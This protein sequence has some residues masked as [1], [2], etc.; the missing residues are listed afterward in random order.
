MPGRTHGQ[1]AVPITF[2]LKAASWGDELV[3][4]RSALLGAGAALPASLAGAAGTLASLGAAAQ[5]VLEAYCDRLDLPV[6]EGPWHAARF[7]L[8]DLCHALGEIGVTGERIAAEIVRLQATEIDELR[9]PAMPGHVG[10][11]TMPQKRN[12][13]TSE[14]LIGSARLLRG[15]VSVVLEGGAHAGE[16]DMGPWSAEWIAVPQAC[17]LASS[18]ADKLAWIVEGLEVRADRMRANLELTR[19]A[20]VA[21]EL[22]MRLGRELGHEA[23]HQLVARAAQEAARSGRRLDEIAI[24]DDPAAPVELVDAADYVGWSAR[25]RRAGGAAHPRASRGNRLTLPERLDTPDSIAFHCRRRRGACL[26]GIVCSREGSMSVVTGEGG[27]I[28]QGSAL[29]RNALGLSGLVIMGI[30]YMGLALT[31]Y[32]NFGIMEGITGPIVPLAFA[33]VT[34][35]MLPTAMSYAIM[36]AR[37]PSTGGTLTWLWEATTPPLGVWLGWVLVIAYIDGCILQPVMFG[38]FFNSL[39][40]YFGISTSYWTA[41][42]TGLISIVVVGVMT[43]KDIRVSAKVTAIFI[44]IEAGFVAL[45]ATYIIIKQAIDGNLSAQPLNPSA[46]TNGW[47]GFQNALLFAVLAI[48]AFDI[49]APMAEETKTPRK[50]VPKATIYVTIGAGLYWV[51]TSFGLINAVPASTMAAYV[52]SGEFTPIYL[53]ADHY[54]GYSP[55]TRAADRHDGRLRGVHGDLDR[56]EPHALRALTRGTRAA[57]V[58]DDRREQDARGTRRSSCS[59]A[60]SSCPC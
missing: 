35:A 5:P 25:G 58:R 44:A 30:A 52:N 47:T 51:I 37:R 46:A 17:I 13:M 50:L 39:L 12:P 26:A 15:A 53:V 19:G 9:E 31:A 28:P 16:R 38:L 18:V 20:I 29:N 49:V 3:H 22:M 60:A 57:A 43:K 42:A 8:R 33:A 27:V 24:G 6:P 36:N 32:F 41:T 1:H 7:L 34:V 56:L 48:A 55:D 23:A 45:L 10:S 4:A 54:I 2:G 59:A 21:E 11:S 14:Y 40:D